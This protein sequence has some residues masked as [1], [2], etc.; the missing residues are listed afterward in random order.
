[1]SNRNLSEKNIP[2]RTSHPCAKCVS[3]QVDEE[4]KPYCSSASEEFGNPESCGFHLEDEQEWER[5][6]KCSFS[7]INTLLA[8]AHIDLIKEIQELLSLG[9][10]RANIE[11]I[12]KPLLSEFKRNNQMTFEVIKTLKGEV[13]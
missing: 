4:G 3:F 10:S 1:M 13:Y 12:F 7:K 2:L 5:I 8:E 9:V 6:I 11:E